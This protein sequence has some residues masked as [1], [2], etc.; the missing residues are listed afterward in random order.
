MSFNQKSIILLLLQMRKAL[1]MLMGKRAN[2]IWVE[3][4]HLSSF[5]VNTL[6]YVYSNW[7]RYSTPYFRS[8]AQ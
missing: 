4:I 1:K 7:V 6:F 3:E 2:I 8:P 5:T